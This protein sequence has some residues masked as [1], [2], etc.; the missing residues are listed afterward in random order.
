MIP[1]QLFTQL[2]T[3]LS[4]VVGNHRLFEK[5]KK[6]KKSQLFYDSLLDSCVFSCVKS[7]Q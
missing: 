1:Y 3:Q 6:K 2:K 7:W 4:Y 5:K